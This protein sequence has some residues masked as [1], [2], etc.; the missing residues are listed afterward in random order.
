MNNVSRISKYFLVA[1]VAMAMVASAVAQQMSQSTAKIIRIKGAARYADA[2]N[3]WKPLKVGDIL[4]AGAIIQTAADSR[5]DMIL[6]EKDPAANEVEW[7][8][9]TS[10]VGAG[11]PDPVCQRD[12]VRLSANSVMAIEKL[13]VADTGTDKI[14]EIALDLRAGKAFGMV[15]KLNG[16]SK[17]EVKVPNAVAGIR[18]TIYNISSDGILSVLVGSV[19]VAYKDSDGNVVTQIVMSGQRFDASTGQITTIPPYDEKEMLRT[20]RTELGTKENPTT[21]VYNNNNY[22]VSP[23]AGNNDDQGQNNNN[24]GQNQP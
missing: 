7:G 21:F 4:K 17:Y 6:G 18:G 11:G 19:V 10:F 2:N 9:T 20:A 8:A 5:V 16:A 15:K 1:G 14:R 23:T 22:W 12:F 24:Q 3:V 13:M